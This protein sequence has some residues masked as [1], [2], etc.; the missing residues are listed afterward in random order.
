MFGERCCSTKES[1]TV[2]EDEV[3]IAEEKEGGTG[4]SSAP[5]VCDFVRESNDILV[6][7]ES[8]RPSART[9]SNHVQMV[10]LLTHRLR[11]N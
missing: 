5:E 7:Y 3:S 11:R 4:K 2:C 10:C 8:Y 6:E 1:S 9:S